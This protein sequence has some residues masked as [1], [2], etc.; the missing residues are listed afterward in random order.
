QPQAITTIKSTSVENNNKNNM[1]MKINKD[2]TRHM[3]NLVKKNSTQSLKRPKPIMLKKPDES[4]TSSAGR[5]RSMESNFKLLDTNL[6]MSR[7]KSMGNLVNS[8]QNINK[9]TNSP[10]NSTT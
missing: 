5:R 9:Q 7:R 1:N 2:H 4:N 6:S 3:K 10:L 8:H